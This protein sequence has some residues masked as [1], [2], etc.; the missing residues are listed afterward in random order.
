MSDSRTELTRRGVVALAAAG[1]AGCMNSDETADEGNGTENG[2][3]VEVDAGNESS[4]GIDNPADAV[5]DETPPALDVPAL[6]AWLVDSELVTDG[7]CRFDYTRT[8]PDDFGSNMPSFLEVSPATVDAHLFQ[9]F[10]Q[11]FMGSFDAETVVENAAA[12]DAFTV[13]GG[14]R[15]YGVVEHDG[16]GPP[17]A[18]GGDAL[19]VG[20][21]YEQRIDA[22]Y[23][24]GERL[25]EIDPEFRRLFEELPHENT[26]SGQYDSPADEDVTV[27]EI[28]L[29]GVS[30]ES[31][32]AETM[33]W[34]FLFEDESALTEDVLAE[35][36]NVSD[37]VES[38]EI[39]GRIARVVGAPPDLE[40]VY[41]DETT[42]GNESDAA[43]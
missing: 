7:N 13:T 17:I 28:Y 2:T 5:G 29:W 27:E 12:A 6:R 18:V 14:Y 40:S 22:R 9:S 37:G 35:L 11:V 43:E 4:G 23:G 33:T 34:A 24:D 20:A 25:T 32:D 21:D 36:E 41:A 38:S 31:P 16:G 3:D 42:D 39:D 8:I 15:G 1:L 30:G 26:I 10:S 19:V